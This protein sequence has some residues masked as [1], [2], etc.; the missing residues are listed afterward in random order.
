MALSALAA[1][2]WPWARAKKSK[3]NWWRKFPLLPVIE[4]LPFC[5]PG[6][7]WFARRLTMRPCSFLLSILVIAFAIAIPQEREAAS[8]L[9]VDLATQMPGV[10]S[11]G[12]TVM[13]A[14]PIVNEGTKSATKVEITS[15][16]LAGASRLSPTTYPVTIGTMQ[17]GA[18]AIV[19][20][21]FSG[22]TLQPEK[23]Y[24]LT[25]KGSYELGGVTTAF[26]LTR[27]I[28]IPPAS[29]G[30]AVSKAGSSPAEKLAGPYPHRTLPRQAN[31]NEGRPPVPVGTLVPGGPPSKS[32][33]VGNLGNT[34]PDVTPFASVAIPANHSVGV[35]E[36]IQWGISEPSGASG[37]G[38]VFVSFNTAAAYSTT[39][40]SSFTI[41][42]LSTIFPETTFPICCDQW[43]Q[44]SP[45][46]D[47]FLWIQQLVEGGKGGNPGQYRLAAASP[48]QIISSKGKKWTSWI[49]KPEQMGLIHA[50]EFDYP[51]MSVGTNYLYL[52]WDTACPKGDTPCNAGREV[53]RIPLA[54]I[55]AGG[56]IPF[57]YTSPS[58]SGVAW[59][60][61]LT[62][63]PGGEIFWAGHNDNSH[64]RVF[65]WAESSDTYYWRDIEHMS[66]TTNYDGCASTA[67]P[68]TVIT[69]PS[70]DGVHVPSWTPSP[71]SNPPEPVTNDWLWRNGDDSITGTT[72]SGNNV[73]FAWA[74][75][76]DSTFPQEYIQMVELDSAKNFARV[77]QVE[78]WNPDFAF[79]LPALS[80]NACTGEI[81]LSVGN[82]GGGVKTKSGVA[83]GTFSN[84]AVGFWGDFLVY[85][86]T[87]SNVNTGLY[88]DYMTIR[89]NNTAS[90]HGAYFDAFGYGLE[91]LSTAGSGAVLPESE[92]NVDVRY[93]VFGRSGRCTTGAPDPRA[94]APAATE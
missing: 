13:I 88:G 90:N 59:A 52:N 44:Y 51:S 82:G 22:G 15:A 25:M 9:P 41:L 38:V 66:Y 86:L 89:Q 16:T 58:V 47:R 68:P 81:G 32:T 71:I 33:G 53:L 42:D 92:V 45:K 23:S 49:L 65:N 93:G 3:A 67:T 56:T 8:S 79:D 29:P 69:C 84:F 75:A 73:W 83:G 40:G 46:I 11:V 20:T 77:N 12:G 54:S 34:S 63:N 28:T 2:K 76:P 31:I 14:L 10:G 18:R 17:S 72:R 57:R 27:S 1:D 91:K 4:S 80:T 7:V 50:T 43:V 21:D 87:A 26:T 5:L 78:I 64:L 85:N 48:A 35:P 62:Q 24:R 60:D 55:K 94:E 19:Q 70:S 39:G 6:T 30:S 36:S 61:D 74:A 37:G